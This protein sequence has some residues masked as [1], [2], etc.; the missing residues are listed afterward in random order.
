MTDQNTRLEF[1][2]LL[3]N[4]SGDIRFM[5]DSS[6]PLK[7]TPNGFEI[8]GWAIHRKSEISEIILTSGSQIL[9]T[10][11]LDIFRPLV[12]QHFTNF[13]NSESAGF[14]L[15]T[16]ALPMGIIVLKIVLKNGKTVSIAEGT[17]AK[18]DQPKLLFMHIAKAAGSTVNSFFA[19]HYLENQY[20]I[21]I[22]SN[23][24]WRSSP[25]DGYYKRAVCG[26]D[27]SRFWYDGP[28]KDRHRE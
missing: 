19:R 16:P 27:F 23:Q 7:K 12:S 14:K 8:A 26:N 6:V 2:E 9:A 13:Y 5:L 4:R 22:E 1:T 24:K 11:K 20:A 28:Q 15:V 17:L 18:V 3:D 21:H 25:D 10:A